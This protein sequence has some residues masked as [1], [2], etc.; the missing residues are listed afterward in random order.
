MRDSI[1]NVLARY[2]LPL[3]GVAVAVWLRLE[4]QPSY[5]DHVPFLLPC[6]VVLAAAWFAGLGP[7]LLATVR[8]HSLR[9]RLSGPGL[10]RRRARRLGADAAL[11]LRQRGRLV[12]HRPGAERRATLRSAPED[13]TR[14]GERRRIEEALRDSE[15]RYRGIVRHA[16]VG[17]AR[18]GLDGMLLD[19]N[20]GLCQAVARERED[21]VGTELSR[22]RAPRRSGARRRRDRDAA[23]RRTRRR[24]ARPA[25]PPQP[26]RQR[27]GER[28]P[29]GDPQRR[30]RAAIGDRGLAR[31]DRAPA[32]R[33]D[34]ALPGRGE[35]VVV[36]A[37]RLPRDAA[38]GG[39]ARRARIRRLVRD[40]HA[41]RRGRD[42]AAGGRARRPSKVKLAKVLHQRYP[43]DPDA[44]YGVPRVLRTGVS[45]RV[46][47][48]TEAAI[49][50]RAPRRRAARGSSPSSACARTCACRCGSRSARSA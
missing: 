19:V 3:A 26:T 24:D 31:R 44:P 40:R 42:R 34:A 20:P 29:V 15:E 7:A 39:A 37:D 10:D 2:G 17:I 36:V 33:S 1:T 45:E 11:R 30:R 25:L 4:L 16:A 43:P 28:H 22:P 47:E 6:V 23:R 32:H 27:L 41:R 5:L 8:R 14:R 46:A 18:S 12:P 9:D 50:E 35:R 49:A 38:E 21:L 48:I 13:H